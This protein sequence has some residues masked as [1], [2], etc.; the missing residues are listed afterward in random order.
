MS[1]AEIS[2]H[3]DLIQS[4]PRN[5]ALRYWNMHS[6]NMSNEALPQTVEHVVS[7]SEN[8]ARTSKVVHER[9]GGVDWRESHNRWYH[10]DTIV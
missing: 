8:G 3:G 2:I 7:W 5:E 9:H 4:Q 6:G 10:C 1:R